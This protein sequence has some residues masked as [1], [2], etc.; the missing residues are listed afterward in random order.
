[1]K[2][3]SINQLRECSIFE[4]SNTFTDTYARGG[5]G[6]AGTQAEPRLLVCRRNRHQEAA[7]RQARQPPI[8]RHLLRGR[9]SGLRVSDAET[10]PVA[11]ITFFSIDS[12]CCIY[13]L[14]IVNGFCYHIFNEFLYLFE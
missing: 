8:S 12:A 4:N 3:K 10:F 9:E 13:I 6:S 1:M 14:Y 5:V 2:Q 11:C 7:L